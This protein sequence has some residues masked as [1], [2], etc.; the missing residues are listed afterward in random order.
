MACEAF[1][2]FFFISLTKSFG[3]F[4]KEETYLALN[5]YFPTKNFV[6][7]ILHSVAIYQQI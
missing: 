7:Y 4:K 3:I 6:K 5:F 1:L 2:S